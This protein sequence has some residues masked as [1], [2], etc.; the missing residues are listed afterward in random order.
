MPVRRYG[1]LENFLLDAPDDAP[2]FVH[3]GQISILVSGYD[4]WFW[5]AYCFVD[6]HFESRES[7]TE[8]LDSQRD[9]PSG[10]V[11]WSETPIWNPRQYFLT[12]LAIRFRWI[13]KEWA[14]I[15]EKLNRRLRKYVG[16]PL[17]GL[18]YWIPDDAELIGGWQE[19]NV[20]T[21]IERRVLF[22]NQSFDVT[23]ELT[24]ALE[25][26]RLLHNALHIL[27]QAWE[28]FEDRELHCFLQEE[29]DVLRKAFDDDIAGHC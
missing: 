18:S 3:E 22:D 8:Y 15:A 17:F 12:V 4:E 29:D 24:A 14:S 11:L 13:T 6:T 20:F 1:E 23:R 16:C 7:T 25:L 10:G 21:P 28:T 2:E 27:I 19:T 26:L 5:R 9:A